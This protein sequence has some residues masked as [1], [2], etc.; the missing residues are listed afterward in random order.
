MIELCSNPERNYVVFKKNLQNALA[1]LVKCRLDH[2]T[3]SDV[4]KEV[5]GRTQLLDTTFSQW[6]CDIRAV[7]LRTPPSMRPNRD[8]SKIAKAASTSEVH[9]LSRTKR[10]AMSPARKRRSHRQISLSKLVS[11]S[12]FSVTKNTDF[13]LYFACGPC[14][15]LHGYHSL[16]IAFRPAA[17]RK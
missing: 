8:C 11:H 10:V 13:K 7:G 14:V 1:L 9:S 16:S 12:R 3:I 5:A 15:L 4:A 6:H 2:E 17:N